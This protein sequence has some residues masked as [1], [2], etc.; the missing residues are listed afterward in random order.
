MN[1][2]PMRYISNDERLRSYQGFMDYDWAK[3]VDGLVAGTVLEYPVFDLVMSWKGASNTFTMPLLMVEGS[4]SFWTSYSQSHIDRSM[5]C[6]IIRELSARL[7]GEVELTNVKKK[8]VTRALDRIVRD[9]EM[10]ERVTRD[11]FV[12]PVDELWHSYL[13]PEQPGTAEFR[14]ILWTSQRLCFVS[15]IHAYEFFV[16]D[17]LRVIGGKPD[18]WRPHFTA[19]EAEAKR[20]LGE[21]IAY[22][23]LKHPEIELARDI[24]NSFAH[25]GG[26]N[27]DNLE[28]RHNI[29]TCPDNR[30]LIWPENNRELFELLKHRA[31]R[32]INAAIDLGS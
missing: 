26:K 25:N 10:A 6:S 5:V 4:A 24:R 19:L 23:C 7:C 22:E 1:K 18:A 28:G 2:E 30:L 20:L 15:L 13:T 31:S 16:Q 12:F 32:F 21:P 27:T 14:L 8:E 3:S 29:R 11:A 9:A 17:V